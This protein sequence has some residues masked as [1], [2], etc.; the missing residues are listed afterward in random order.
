MLPSCCYPQQTHVDPRW[1]LTVPDSMVHGPYT[2]FRLMAANRLVL[3]RQVRQ[4]LWDKHAWQSIADRERERADTLMVALEME[5]GVSRMRLDQLGD[6]REDLMD[7]GER[8]GRLSGWATV[9]KVGVA[10]AGVGVLGWVAGQVVP[11]F[12]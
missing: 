3:D 2:D 11:L 9:G 8:A 1:T 4:A 6:L 12:R 7:C 10:V 5:K